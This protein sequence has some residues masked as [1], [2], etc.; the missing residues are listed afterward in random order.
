MTGY[1]VE[2]LLKNQ[3]SGWIS[4]FDGKKAILNADTPYSSKWKVGP[5]GCKT[6]S[7][8]GLNEKK[9]GSG[10]YCCSKKGR[11]NGKGS[12]ICPSD[13]IQFID[14]KITNGLPSKYYCL[15]KGELFY[16]RFRIGGRSYRRSY[17][18]IKCFL[19]DG[20]M[21][22]DVMYPILGNSNPY[23]NGSNGETIYN[24]LCYYPPTEPTTM[25]LLNK[26]TGL[27]F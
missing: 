16:N 18:N 3:S 8:A 11:F 19:V 26:P 7:K 24:Y 27:S 6:F 21:V 10:G 1:R 2:N 17:V 4:L 15:T 23:L 25:V 9:C 5:K 13:A 22:T 14:D 20:Q 12:D